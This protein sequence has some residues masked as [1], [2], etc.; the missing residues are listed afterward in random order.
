MSAALS[1]PVTAL[2]PNAK[3]RA[4]VLILEPDLAVLDYLRLTLGSLYSLSLFSDE[5][6]LLSA[7][8]TRLTDAVS[9]IADLGG[10]WSAGDLHSP[11]DPK[12]LPHDPSESPPPPPPKVP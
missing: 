5:Q 1:Y 2:R 3:S 4:Q 11:W 8:Q 6:T 7:E 9:L 10:G 12:S